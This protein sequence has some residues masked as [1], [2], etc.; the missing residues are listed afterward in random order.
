MLDF[1]FTSPIYL[2]L[3]IVYFLV[4]SIATF[5]IR[6]IQARR[7]GEDYPMLPSWTGIFGW[8]QW[9]LF[10]VLFILNWKYALIIF[11]VKFVLKVLPVLETIGNILMSPFKPR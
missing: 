5:D 3:T 8:L 6:L 1:D 11:A 7:Q 4:A 9:A 10:I 2:A